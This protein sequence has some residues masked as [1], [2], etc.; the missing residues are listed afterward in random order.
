MFEFYLHDSILQN[1]V[2]ELALFHDGGRLHFTDLDVQFRDVFFKRRGICDAYT[3]LNRHH[4]CSNSCFFENCLII[5]IFGSHYN[6]RH[7]NCEY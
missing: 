5:A 6:K 2:C 3:Y 7:F 1:I 4:K